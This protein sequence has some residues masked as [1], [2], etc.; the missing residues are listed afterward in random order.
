M[1]KLKS[2]YFRGAA[3]QKLLSAYEFLLRVVHLFYVVRK[4]SFVRKN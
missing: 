3:R 4:S 2:I 1:A